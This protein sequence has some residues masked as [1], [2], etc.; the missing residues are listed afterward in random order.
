VQC[1]FSRGRAEAGLRTIWRAEQR[2]SG[3][4]QNAGAY[5]VLPLET[6]LTPSHFNAQLQVMIGRTHGAACLFWDAFL[7][8]GGPHS[9]AV[10]VAVESFRLPTKPRAAIALRHAYSAS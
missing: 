3:F 5:G 6:D 7:A 9:Q 10:Y 1:S 4:W 8:F 2:C